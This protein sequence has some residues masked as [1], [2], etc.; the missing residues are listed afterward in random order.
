[1][2]TVGHE[3]ACWLSLLYECSVT[4]LRTPRLPFEILRQQRTR[5]SLAFKVFNG[6]KERFGW[7]VFLATTVA[8]VNDFVVE[9]VAMRVEFDVRASRLYMSID[10]FYL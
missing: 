9:K 7:S 2:T 6:I 10:A 8:D 5:P 4:I 3:K 1:M